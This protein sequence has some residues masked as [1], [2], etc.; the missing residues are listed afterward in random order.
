MSALPP[1]S[2][3]R[4]FEA[5]ARLGSVTQAAAELHVTHSAISQQ[6][7]QLENLLGIALLQ[8]EGRGLRLTEEG[9][10]YALQVRRALRDI[11][12]ATRLARAR[13]AEAEL[14]VAVVPSFGQHW[15][16]PRLPRFQQRHPQYRV[17][18]LASLEVIDLRQG[19]AD[20][21]IRMGQ[22]AW[23]GLARQRL[24]EDELVAVC[25][26]GFNAGQLPASPR[27]VLAAPLLFGFESWL[28][29]CQAAGVEPPSAAPRLTANDSN[30]ILEALR[31]GQGV[32][33]ERRSLVAD[34]LARGE[35]VQLGETRA[36]Y[37]HPY[38][39]VW[40]E[41]EGAKARVADFAA[42][43]QDEVAAYLSGD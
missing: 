43:L 11:A 32:A 25:A 3:L 40:P 18:L 24:F 29:W 35:L 16:V 8:R 19:Q 15:L 9:R 22:G 23:D 4:S 6:L 5:V 10:L 36:P 17:R 14:V 38:W 12:E 27:E 28:P 2:T 7:R 37:A 39:L 1:L 42:W 34:A 33:V 13:P 21:A 30:L 26:P 31:R 41:R 20:V